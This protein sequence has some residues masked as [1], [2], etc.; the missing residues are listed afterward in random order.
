M[1]GSRAFVCSPRLR[2]QATLSLKFVPRGSMP[3]T[4]KRLMMSGGRKYSALAAIETAEPPGPPG[5][6]NSVP[7]F[8]VGCV[9]RERSSATDVVGPVGS[10]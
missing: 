4:S 5:F 7:S 6:T 3:T 10:S 2:Q 8:L 1:S 9:A